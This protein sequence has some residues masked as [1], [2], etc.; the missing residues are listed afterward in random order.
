MASSSSAPP[1]GAL[2]PLPAAGSLYFDY[3]EAVPVGA[4]IDMDLNGVAKEGNEERKRCRARA[5]E[6]AAA[7]LVDDRSNGTSF[8]EAGALPG[9]VLRPARGCQ[10]TRQ[11]AVDSLPPAEANDR[12]ARAC[13]CW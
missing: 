9:G 3:L 13:R 6:H 1:S 2:E 4:V 5:Q 8:R 12:C 7:V 10:P 11:V